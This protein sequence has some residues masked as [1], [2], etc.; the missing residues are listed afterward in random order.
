[1][2]KHIKRRGFVM[3]AF[4]L[5]FA[6]AMPVWADVSVEDAESYVSRANADLESLVNSGQTGSALE[7]SVRRFF[8]TYADVPTVA[9]AV[10]GGPWRGMS[11]QQ[12]RDYTSAFEGYVVRKYA[13]KFDVL[14]GGRA[15]ITQSRDSGA[16][17]VLVSAE[18]VRSIGLPVSVDYQV[19]DQSGNIKILDLR[20][21]GVSLISQ[22]RTAV[23]SIL[24]RNGG[25]VDALTA[26]LNAT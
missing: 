22:E 24:E 7:E 6:T 15:E 17:G 10:L 9:R 8:R 13:S 20:L 4:A 2:V 16:A 3:S 1:M 21:E 26:E 5:L 14:S 19:S 23:R 25:D 12:K 18:F 11:D